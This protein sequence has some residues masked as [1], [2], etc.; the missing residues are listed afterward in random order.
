LKISACFVKNKGDLHIS[1][2]TF[3]LNPYI[4]PSHISSKYS[5]I[6]PFQGQKLLESQQYSLL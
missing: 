6:Q 5:N 2:H 1:K 3:F 4:S